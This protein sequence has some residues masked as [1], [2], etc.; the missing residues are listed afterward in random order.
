MCNQDTDNETGTTSVKKHLTIFVDN[1]N[2]RVGIPILL[3][4][5]G[6][7]GVVVVLLWAVFFRGK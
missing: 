3:Y 7:P 4:L 1:V 5:L 6:V 2:G